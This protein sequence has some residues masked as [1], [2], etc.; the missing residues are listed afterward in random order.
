MDCKARALY[1]EKVFL[2]YTAQWCREPL[3]FIDKFERDNEVKLKK[4]EID[5]SVT[6][7]I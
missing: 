1:S 4:I 7:I 6:E 5:K 3:K 2:R